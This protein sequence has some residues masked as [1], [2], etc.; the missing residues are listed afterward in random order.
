VNRL[1]LAAL[2]FVLLLCCAEP[3]QLGVVS[4]N[5]M[6]LCNRLLTANEVRGE[7]QARVECSA[8]QSRASLR[9]K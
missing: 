3:Q 5:G 9:V 8:E 7:E 4:V 1:G 2:S 6:G